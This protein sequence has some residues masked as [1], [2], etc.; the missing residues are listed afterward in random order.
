MFVLAKQT[1]LIKTRFSSCGHKH[2]PA[3]IPG[4]RRLQA[5]QSSLVCA[6]VQLAGQ[7]AIR[8]V[9]ISRM[10]WNS[11]P[12][13]LVIF[14]ESSLKTHNFVIF[15]CSNFLILLS[16][17]VMHVGSI[18][19]LHRSFIKTFLAQLSPLLVLQYY[20]CLDI[21]IIVGMIITLYI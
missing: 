8:G 13:I 11:P 1:L 2:I 18:S 14:I 16:K 7:F 6:I 5:K 4:I 15:C 20:R 17:V 21:P 3:L 12:L 10:D 9:Q 19:Y